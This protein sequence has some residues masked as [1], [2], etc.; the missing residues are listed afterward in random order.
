MQQP[1]EGTVTNFVTMLASFEY[2]LISKAAAIHDTFTFDLHTCMVIILRD[3]PLK[4]A[5]I[6]NGSPGAPFKEGYATH[7]PF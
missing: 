7:K 2:S 3:K 4:Q 5:G 6:A 1:I